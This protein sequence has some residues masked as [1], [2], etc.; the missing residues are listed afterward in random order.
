M[1][2]NITDEY[3]IFAYEC[4]SYIF[5]SDSE[6]VSYQEYIQEGH[7]PRDHILYHAA[8]VLDRIEEFKEDIDT[9]IKETKNGSL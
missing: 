3:K 9:Y 1:I 7:D 6:Q 5:D 2:I 4:A 8:V